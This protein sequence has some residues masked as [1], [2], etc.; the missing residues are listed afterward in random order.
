[1]L[2]SSEYVQLIAQLLRI[3]KTAGY[4]VKTRYYN[5][6]KPM[7]DELSAFALDLAM[8]PTIP[9]VNYAV[10]SSGIIIV[11]GIASGGSAIVET[12]SESGDCVLTS[13]SST[14][15]NLVLESTGK[16]RRTEV[17]RN[18]ANGIVRFRNRQCCDI[19]IWEPYLQK[20]LKS[21]DISSVI[22]YSEILG[23]FPCC[24]L[25]TNSEF[26]QKAGNILADLFESYSNQVETTRNDRFLDQAISEVAHATGFGSDTI[27]RSLESYEFDSN[28]ISLERLRKLGMRLSQNQIDRIFYRDCLN[29]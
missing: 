22:P 23:T 11:M 21:S 13:E 20:V 25:S 28:R 6:V 19:A 17:Y 3:A 24:V 26:S 14:M 4:T 27:S 9:A 29:A 7:L 18:P 15:I 16:L 5:S 1:M 8:V 12:N 2:K 10:L